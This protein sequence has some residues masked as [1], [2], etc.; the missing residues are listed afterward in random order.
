M[1]FTS[2]RGIARIFKSLRHVRQLNSR[3]INNF[4]MVVIVIN[5]ISMGMETSHYLTEEY[6]PVLTLIDHVALGIFTLEIATKLL[7]SR[8]RFFRDPWNVFDFLIVGVSLLTFLPQLSVLR[9]LR[10]LRILLLISFMPNLRFLVQSLLLALPG[11]LGITLLL[12]IMFYVFGIIA[13]QTFGT[14]HPQAFGTLGK[15]LYSLFRITTLDGA[16]TII[17]SVLKNHAYAYFFFIPFILFSSY[18]TLNIFIAI[19][20]NSMREARLRNEAEEKNAAQAI[21]TDASDRRTQRII[22]TLM[23]KL[24]EIDGRIT[25]LE[26]AISCGAKTPPESRD[27]QKPTS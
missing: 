20:I 6:G 11:I 22:D 13:T 17:N 12:V 23:N 24:N 25:R 16:W 15:S 1:A 18:I 8:L 9:S 27:E 2:K 14:N 4:I 26:T 7:I 19:I 10:I 21:E 3:F 5:A